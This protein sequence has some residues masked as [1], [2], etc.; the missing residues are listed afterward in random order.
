MQRIQSGQKPSMRTHRL[1]VLSQKPIDTQKTY[2]INMG[3][4]A[5]VIVGPTYKIQL[6]REWLN[7]IHDRQT[8]CSFW[9]FSVF[10]WKSEEK[11][12][13][14]RSLFW[15]YV[16]NWAH[17]YIFWR[18]SILKCD[19][20]KIKQNVFV[21][22]IIKNFR[23]GSINVVFWVPF[24]SHNVLIRNDLHSFKMFALSLRVCC[25]PQKQQLEPRHQDNS[26]WTNWSNVFFSY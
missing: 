11:I 17:C 18:L 7:F 8:C 25:W 10:S 14:K 26:F 5:S 4:V 21:L 24:K 1:F 19:F 22:H 15:G 2:T 6:F 20:L 12:Q 16:K 3:A 23:D 9:T 13:E